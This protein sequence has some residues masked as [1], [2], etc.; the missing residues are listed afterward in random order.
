LDGDDWGVFPA[1]WKPG[2]KEPGSPHSPRRIWRELVA[3]LSGHIIDIRA[4]FN[5]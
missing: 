4:P 5:F 1:K 2:G 3:M